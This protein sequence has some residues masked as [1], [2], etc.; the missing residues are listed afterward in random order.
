MSQAI[1]LLLPWKKK[2]H[3]IYLGPV[4]H[5][6]SPSHLNHGHLS[7]STV[8]HLHISSSSSSSLPSSIHHTL[9]SCYSL[10]LSSPLPP[11]QYFILLFSIITSTPAITEITTLLSPLHYH[12]SYIFC[13]SSPSPHLLSPS[14]TLGCVPCLHHPHHHPDNLPHSPQGK[15][16]VCIGCT[17]L[18]KSSMQMQQK[19]A[20]HYGEWTNFR[21]AW[22]RFIIAHKPKVSC[23]IWRGRSVPCSTRIIYHR[24]L[25]C[26]ASP[27]CFLFSHV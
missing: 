22:P 5:F 27:S 20:E 6:S 25:V 8:L 18:Y 13:L 9:V 23:V 17:V 4:L 21:S 12:S 24:A 11:L 1:L 2:N 15:V 14:S 3:W 16:F 10:T 19:A 26:S 7:F